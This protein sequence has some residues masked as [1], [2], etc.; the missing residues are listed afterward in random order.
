MK[1][2]RQID[3][4]CWPAAGAGTEAVPSRR[5]CR[6]L[7][8]RCFLPHSPLRSSSHSHAGLVSHRSQVTEKAKHYGISTLLP[9]PVDPAQDLVLQYELKLTNGLSCGGAYLKFVTADD[10][11]KPEGL[12]DDTP[13]TVM[14]GPDKCGATNKVRLAVRGGACCPVLMGSAGPH[15][16]CARPACWRVAM[17]GLALMALPAHPALQRHPQAMALFPMQLPSVHKPPRGCL[18]PAGAPDPA[19]QVPQDRQ[20]RGE[21]PGSAAQRAH[22]RRVPSS[23][24]LGRFPA[25]PPQP[26]CLQRKLSSSPTGPAKR[27]PLS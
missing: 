12:K 14:F 19:P 16:K 4:P 26:C 18:L 11:F 9:E 5:C 24:G 6:R 22:R 8:G 13:Y 21:A 10:S 23:G 20:D 1:C 3:Q 15:W 17:L 7:L 2:N 27:A 25:V